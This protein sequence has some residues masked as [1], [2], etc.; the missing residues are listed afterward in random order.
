MGADEAGLSPSQ[1]M[2]LEELAACLVLGEGFSPEDAVR[3]AAELVAE[4]IDADALVQLACQ[5]ADGKVLDGREVEVLFRTA[6]A[7]VGL[8][9]PSREAAG[10]LMARWIAASMIDGVISPAEGALRVGNLWREC[11]QAGELVAMLQLSD[12]WESSIGPDEAA[13]QAEMLA[14]APK[15]IAAADR[16][17]AA[18]G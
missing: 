3:V 2:R 5:P 13:V 15:V 7:E 8:E 1:R 17:L 12:A 18:N 4:G 11:G 16:F 9:P 6:L 14:F 10:W